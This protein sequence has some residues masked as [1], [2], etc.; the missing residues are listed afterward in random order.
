MDR[1]EAVSLAE[2]IAA[3]GFAVALLAEIVRI[4]GLATPE[5]IDDMMRSPASDRPSAA[6]ARRLSAISRIIDRLE[7]RVSRGREGRVA[8]AVVKSDEPLVD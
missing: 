6:V 4:Q 2:R 3:L 1:S 5:E 8:L 7:E